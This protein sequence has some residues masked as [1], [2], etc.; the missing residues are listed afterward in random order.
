[1]IIKQKKPPRKFNVGLD[2]SITIKDSG[3]IQLETNEQVTFVNGK[4]ETYSIKVGSPA[5]K[6]S[7]RK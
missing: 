6:I 1:M 5:K 2:K 7:M 4:I 3:T